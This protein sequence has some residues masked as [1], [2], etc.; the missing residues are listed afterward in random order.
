MQSHV[1]GTRNRSRIQPK[2]YIDNAI[3]DSM[4]HKL[5]IRLA[6]LARNRCS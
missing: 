2:M 5:N 6:D 4:I 3:E 1:T